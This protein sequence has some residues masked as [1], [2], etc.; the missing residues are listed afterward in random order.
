MAGTSD[1]VDGTDAVSIRPNTEMPESARHRLMAWLIANGID[2]DS[3]PPNQPIVIQRDR[4]TYT[5]VLKGGDGEWLRSPYAHRHL[6]TAEQT[7]PL[8]LALP[9]APWPYEVPDMTADIA[10]DGG[11]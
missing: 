8:Q 9:E 11:C 2:A 1:R 3:I 4:I 6:V 10:A 7:V 5:E